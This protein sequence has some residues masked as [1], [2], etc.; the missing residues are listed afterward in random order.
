MTSRRPRAALGIDLGTSGVKVV[1]VDQRGDALGRATRTYAVDA[2]RP[3]W[4]ETDPRAWEAATRDAVAEVL[5]GADVELVGIGVD[6]QMHGT[7][8]VDATG[9][10]LRPAVLWPDSRAT[11]QL[12]AWRGLP[13]ERR[14]ALANPLVPGMT[15]PVLAWLAEHEPEPEPGPETRAYR[16]LLPKDWLR[17]RL[18][19]DALVTDPTDASATLLWDV[20]ADAWDVEVAGR[21]GVDAALLPAVVAPGTTV[22]TTRG[23]W[24]LPSGVPVAAGCADAAATLLGIG[25]THGRL[26]LTVGTGAQAVLPGVEPQPTDP[27]TFHTYRA[28]DGWYAMAAVLNA[29]LALDRV[30]GLLGAEW[31][32]LY[33][34]YDRGRDLPVFVPT[35]AGE[36]LPRP[37]DPGGG[38]SG[39]TLG[40]TRADLMAAALEGVAFGIM[41]AVEQLPAAD[42]DLVD[43]AGGGTRNP[44]LVQLLADV[45]G[46]PLRP[47]HHPDA[48]AL[49]A[50]RLGFRA[51]GV[52]LDVPAPTTQPLVEPHPSA[53]LEERWERFVERVDGGGHSLR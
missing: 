38:W 51:A 48:T 47:V 46:R 17:T 12:T 30:V 23:A 15:G 14:A 20:T 29:G 1:L 45:L 8:L 21:V 26:L 27:P 32:E 33:A 37:V 35:L 52:D 41:R 34:A 40:T 53:A 22:G 42:E 5:A 44:V 36:R 50:A 28:V 2:P 24:G 16:V 10:P 31:D 9:E 4:A 19:P 18:V 39:I 7:V 13:Q 11:E 6:G 3:G 49:G 25:V 43:V